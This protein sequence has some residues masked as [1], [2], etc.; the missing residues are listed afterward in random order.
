MSHSITR[1]KYVPFY[2]WSKICPLYLLVKKVSVENMSVEKTSVEKT[3]RCPYFHTLMKIHFPD[4]I[5]FW[6]SR[7]KKHF[8]V[9][10][11]WKINIFNKL[12]RPLCHSLKYWKN[13][14]RQPHPG[15][16]RSVINFEFLTRLQWNRA[17]CHV[18]DAWKRS[19]IHVYGGVYAIRAML[20]DNNIFLFR[21]T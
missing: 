11:C 10:G 21:T 19:L 1:W 5:C 13:Y 17:F 12:N 4:E 20:N 7:A 14:N 16:K 9:I 15:K 18:D 2:Y 8:R 6:A 3:S